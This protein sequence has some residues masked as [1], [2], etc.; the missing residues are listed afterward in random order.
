MP[1]PF[2]DVGVHLTHPPGTATRYLSG[3]KIMSAPLPAGQR[4][5]RR[6]MPVTTEDRCVADCLRHLTTVDGVVIADAALHRDPDLREAI[7]FMLGSTAGWPY[8]GRALRSWALVDGRRESPAESWSYV[9]MARQGLPVPEPQV[10]IYG[11]GG[12]F[13]ARVDAWWDEVA[14]VG[15]ADGRVKYGIGTDLD[16]ESARRALEKEKHREDE[17]RRG[18]RPR[19]ALGDARPARRGPLGA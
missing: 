16:L 14:V 4:T 3:L 7:A 12:R 1:Q 9:A 5:M 11:P 13:I 10:S 15:E 8:S 2:A 18:R 17:L 6:G 19:G